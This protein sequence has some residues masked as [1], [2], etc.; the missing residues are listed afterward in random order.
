MTMVSLWPGAVRT[1]AIVDM[2]QDS[3][4]VINLFMKI[5]I[6]RDVSQIFGRF[7]ALHALMGSLETTGELGYDGPSGTRKIGLSYA[8]FV[9]CI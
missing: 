9:K 8:K 6:V 7:G 1:E 3:E 5:P 2:L 4:K